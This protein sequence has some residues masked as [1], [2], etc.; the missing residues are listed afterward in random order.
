MYCLVLLAVTSFLLALLVTPACRRLFQH[1]GVVDQPDG[2]RHL[3]AH[4]I[5]RVG[6]IAVLLSYLGGLAVLVFS[7]LSRHV[8]VVAGL[9]LA[10]RICVAAALVFAVGILDDVRGLAPWQKFAG[11]TMAACVA[12]WAGVQLTGF[13]GFTLPPG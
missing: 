12:F 3:H 5:P 9:P 1:W 4:P 2:G 8:M 10:A 13:A 11:Q 6:G 7:P